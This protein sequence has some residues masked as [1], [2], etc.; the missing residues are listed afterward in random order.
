MD[1]KSSKTMRQM[2]KA[3]AQVHLKKLAANPSDGMGSALPVPSQRAVSDPAAAGKRVYGGAA[4]AALVLLAMDRNK[5]LELL[6]QLEPD[7]VQEIMRQAENMGSVDAQLL[8]SIV[9]EFE[10]TFREG[11]KFLGTVDEVRELVEEALRGA[12]ASTVEPPM[13]MAGYMP[14]WPE[15]AALSDEIIQKYVMAQNTRVSAFILSKFDA[16]RAA[17][18]LKGIPVEQ[19]N[20]LVACLLEIKPSSPS[21]ERAIEDGIRKDL[22]AVAAGSGSASH[23]IVAGLLNALDPAL[24]SSAIDHLALSRPDDAKIVRK[25]LFKFED[26]PTL[27]AKSRTAVVER[28]PVERLVLALKDA[29][30]ELV[31][32]V[33][34]AMPPRGRRM[35][36]SEL[37]S[38]A[39]ASDKSVQEARRFVAQSVLKLAASGE[40]E[41]LAV[42]PSGGST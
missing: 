25:L 20:S 6:K 7:E 32:S 40:I 9:S 23:Q 27:A 2:Q 38:G 14:P 24:T 13:A 11:I 39:V 12:P 18:L 1:A 8:V 5:A 42:D 4:K 3:G 22:L 21:I 41:A 31:E 19:C 10:H 16:Q 29:P 30:T 26:F 34:S 33:L 35:A 28:V 37:Q 15:M 17:D 36:E